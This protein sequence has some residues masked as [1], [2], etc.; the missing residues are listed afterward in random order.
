MNKMNDVKEPTKN[1]IDKLPSAV[2]KS[3][4]MPKPWQLQ[5]T[6]IVYIG[7]RDR[8]RFTKLPS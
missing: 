7:R 6:R 2:T 8:Q 3:R 1:G 5:V 4:F